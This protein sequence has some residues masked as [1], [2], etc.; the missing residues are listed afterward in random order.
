MA[1][2]CKN[3]GDYFSVPAIST[4]KTPNPFCSAKCKR[5]YDKKRAKTIRPEGVKISPGTIGAIT[6]LMVSTDLLQ[7]GYHVFRAQSPSCP[8]DLI[9]FMTGNAAIK[10]EV[11]T[12][13]IDSVTGKRSHGELKNNEFDILAVVYPDGIRYEPDL[14]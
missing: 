1:V 3:C 10:I 11:K 6:E 5:E 14:S 7:K 13:V 8:C 9:A 2:P 12:G 4:I